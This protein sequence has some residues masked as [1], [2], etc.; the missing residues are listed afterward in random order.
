MS[1]LDQKSASLAWVEENRLAREE[2]RKALFKLKYAKEVTTD[3]TLKNEL[4]PIISQLEK[5]ILYKQ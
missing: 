4:T 2:T 3:E 1:H 5:I